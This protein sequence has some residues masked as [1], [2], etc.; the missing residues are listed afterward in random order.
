MQCR[1]KIGHLMKQKKFLTLFLSQVFHISHLSPVVVRGPLSLPSL[2]VFGTVKVT[3]IVPVFLPK[4]YIIEFLSISSLWES[5]GS[6]VS[7]TLF[8][9]IH[10][11]FTFFEIFLPHRWRAALLSVWQC[12]APNSTL[13]PLKHSLHLTHFISRADTFHFISREDTFHFIFREDTSH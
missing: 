6:P 11:K 3:L 8:Y 7:I 5:G 2:L 9:H 13:A 10:E 1:L 12:S 4:L